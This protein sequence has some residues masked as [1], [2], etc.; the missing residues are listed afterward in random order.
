MHL[1]DG[2]GQYNNSSLLNYV[3]AHKGIGVLG[4]SGMKG[5]K[6]VD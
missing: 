4:N 6:I 5:L 3:L 1:V 2:A